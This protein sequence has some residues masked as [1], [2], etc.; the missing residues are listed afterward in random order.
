MC[1]PFWVIENNK[2][3]KFLERKKYSQI[4]K[5]TIWCLK[6]LCKFGIYLCEI[7]WKVGWRIK[8]KKYWN[9]EVNKYEQ[10]TIKEKKIWFMFSL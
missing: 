2:K 3:R 4:S 6:Y 7:L 8:V 10:T 5:D 9:L 1:P